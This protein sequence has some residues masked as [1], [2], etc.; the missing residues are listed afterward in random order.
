MSPRA[1]LK[2]PLILACLACLF[3]VV[4]AAPPDVNS[5]SRAEIQKCVKE[6]GDLRFAVREKASCR[7][8]DL[9]LDA[10]PVLEEAT[11]SA[12]PEVCQR[13]WRIID[14]W[15]SEG[16]VPALLFQLA[17]R[18]EEVRAGAAYALGRLGASAKEAVPALTEAAKD[19]CEI[20]RCSASEALKAI[21][22]APALVLQ[23]SEMD[24]PIV[25]GETVIY[26]IDLANLG[27]AAA[28]N[29]RFVMQLPAKLELVRVLGP[30][31]RQ[32]GQRVVSQ[33]QSLDPGSKLQWH[34]H[35]K[36]KGTG[37]LRFTVEAL[38]DQ[39]Q[40]VQETKTL[41]AEAAVKP[42]PVEP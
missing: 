15:A 6:L 5:T 30:N 42:E 3:T 39:L 19:R 29:V 41:K 31:F 8:L 2:P 17:N 23:V 38:S 37:K 16:K 4:A 1:S 18:S 27:M 21:E 14:Q 7:L 40:A 22:A 34:I 32:D 26:R 36:P 28:T 35:V 33:P 12:D 20:V 13:A 24:D 10:L 9:G 11:H 25:E